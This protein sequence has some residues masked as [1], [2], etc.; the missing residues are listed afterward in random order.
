MRQRINGQVIAKEIFGQIKRSIGDRQLSL[1]I[2]SVGVDPV[3]ASYIKIKEKTARAIGVRV[4]H[5]H[6]DETDTDQ[7]VDVVK[8]L[9]NQVDGV[10]VQLPLPDGIDQQAV[11][12]AIDPNKDV[13]SLKSSSQYHGP[14]AMAVLHILETVE[15]QWQS[16]NIV[17]VGQ[18][19][20]VGQ[21][22]VRLLQSL[23]GPQLEI[24]VIDINTDAQ[25]RDRLLQNAEVV[26][27]GVGQPGLIRP[28]DIKDGVILIDAGTSTDH[29]ELLGDIDPDCYAK[30]LAYT[31][32]PGGVGPVAV[33]KLFEN[34]AQN[35][36]A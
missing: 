24:R 18:G 8:Q 20:L 36:R 25:V 22:V 16:K 6:F 19:K 12:D 5:R 17:V 10:V 2:V 30:S 29:G 11:I 7:L 35:Q 3:T 28:D 15:P 34:L 33:A 23:P 13:D 4:E 21:P 27:S 14:V 9:N 26:I 31:P 1:G 32:V